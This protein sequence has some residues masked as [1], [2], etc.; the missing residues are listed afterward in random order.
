MVVE[1]LA[2]FAQ[3]VEWPQLVQVS[4]VLQTD[5]ESAALA[6]RLETSSRINTMSLSGGGTCRSVMQQHARALSATHW[7][8]SAIV[9]RV[10]RARISPRRTS[11]LTGT[12]R[13]SKLQQAPNVS[14]HKIF[15]SLLTTLHPVVQEQRGPKASLN[16]ET[17]Y[18]IQISL[19]PEFD[20]RIDILHPV[21]TSK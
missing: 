4:C 5:L 16:K 13:D 19:S 20:E 17:C 1:I 9:R 12:R 11:V 6:E 7:Q 3:L 15:N 18:V 2:V 14:L 10:F 8:K 21:L